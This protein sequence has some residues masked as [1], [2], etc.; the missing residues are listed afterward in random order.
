MSTYEGEVEPLDTQRLGDIF[1][2]F[3]VFSAMGLRA[4][5]SASF[6]E[7]CAAVDCDLLLASNWLTSNTNFSIGSILPCTELSESSGSTDLSACMCVGEW[8]RA[9]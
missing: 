7:V 4:T 8:K 3:D 2:T 9:H 6:T 5:N 1:A